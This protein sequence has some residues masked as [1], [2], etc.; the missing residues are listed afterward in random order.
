MIWSEDVHEKLKKG[1]GD[2]ESMVPQAVA[3]EIIKDRMFDFGSER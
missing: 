1:R 2:W 3:D